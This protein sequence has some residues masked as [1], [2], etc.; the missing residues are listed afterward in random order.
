[1]KPIQ[2]LKLELIELEDQVL[3]LDKNSKMI[4]GDWY[5]NSYYNTVNRRD[6]CISSEKKASGI[7]VCKV[8]S[9]T[10]QLEGLPLLMIE[11]VVDRLAYDYCDNTVP[12][13]VTRSL[14][15]SFKR[16]YLK[17]KETYKFTEV[18]LLIAFNTGRTYEKSNHNGVGQNELVDYIKSL[19][20]KELWIEV[21]ERCKCGTTCEFNECRHEQKLKITNN[22]IKAVWK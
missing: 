13:D 19:T 4:G 10:K 8:I 21:Y 12:K 22:Q 6:G 20:K 16:G 7:T 11:D 9:S 5:Y 17:A 1:M 15:Y 14:H 2:E 18:D 3:L